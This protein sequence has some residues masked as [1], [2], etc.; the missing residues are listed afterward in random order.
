MTTQDSDNTPQFVGRSEQTMKH[1]E[2]R[3]CI[4][5]GGAGGIGSNLCRVFG[6][7][8][9]K[10]VVADTGFDVEG[11][12]GMDA[13]K[14]EAIVDEIRE[15]GG[16]AVPFV[17]DVADM[18][19]AE[20]MIQT[21]LDTFGGLDVLVCA[22]GILRERMI[23]NMTEDEWD[24]LVRAH[25][26]GCF[27]PTKFASIYWRANR[28]GQHR[29]IVY[30]T[31]DAGIRGAA[32]QPN[33]S[34]AHAA[35][36]GLMRSN[37]GALSRYGV[38]TNCIAPGASTRMTDRGRGIAPGRSGAQRISRRHGPRSEERRPNR[39]LARLRPERSG[40]R[41]NLRRERPPHITV[42]GARPRALS[43]FRRAADRCRHPLR[44]L[45]TDPRCRRLP[46]QS[47]PPRVGLGLHAP[48]SQRPM[49]NSRCRHTRKGRPSR[50][51]AVPQLCHPHAHNSVT[52]APFPSYPRLPRVS[53]REQHQTPSRTRSPPASLTPSVIPGLTGNP[54]PPNPQ[55]QHLTPTY[56]NRPQ[57]SSPLPPLRGG[58]CRGATEGGPPHLLTVAIRTSVHIR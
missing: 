17:G 8:G 24:G 32:G 34:A 46:T 11:R 53:R 47:A 22:H 51:T 35:K 10:V 31:S 55:Q 19:T 58:R 40:Q 12:F 56:P 6:E 29:R 38:T 4:I 3:I 50:K 49:C 45:A 39:R 30:F 18:D 14:V 54:E 57:S 16:E 41:P 27:A 33:Y 25:L 44:S 7:Q 28:E 13:S 48:L 42:L 23:F 43:P 37:V 36:L 2:G 20:N 1:L 15:A 5:T 21:A 26:K 9:A 52:P